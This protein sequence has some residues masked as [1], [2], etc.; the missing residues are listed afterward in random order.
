MDFGLTDEQRAIRSTVRDFVRRELVP[1]EQELMRREL[2]GER[3]LPRAELRALREKARRSGLWG[4]ATP[5]EYGGAGLDPV[6]QAL[7][8]IELGHTFVPFTFGGAADNIL[9]AATGDQVET[10]LK[11]TIA[12]TRLSCFALTEADAGSDLNALRTTARRDGPDWLITGEKT[13]I[14]NGDDADYALVFAVTGDRTATTSGVTCFLVDRSAGWTSTPIPMMSSWRAASLYFDDVR[15]GAGHVLG[16]VGRGFELAMRW[17][18]RGRL[19]A[20]CKGIGAA[21]RLL[22]MAVEHANLRTT[23]GQP[24]ADRQAIQWMIADSAVELESARLLTLRAA[25]LT[26]TPADA[27]YAS[28]MAKLSGTTMANAVVDRVLQIHGGLGYTKD[29]PIERWYRELR[30]LRIFEGT[31][32]IQRRTIARGVLGG[33]VHFDD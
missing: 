2:A 8:N 25:W 12:G 33:R 6:T 18:G 21:Q 10:Y 16:E 1:L 3:E 32:E 30:V 5:P 17:I 29:L 27:R 26:T 31:D 24:L 7:V 14:S 9:Y 20:P 4:V 19:L 13:F 22:A 28:S 15:V 11:P 23:W